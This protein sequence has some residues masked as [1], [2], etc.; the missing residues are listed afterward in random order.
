M[1]LHV[2]AVRPEQVQDAER[3]SAQRSESTIDNSD[4]ESLA[5]PQDNANPTTSRSTQLK[6]L[7]GSAQ[8]MTSAKELDQ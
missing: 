4:G 3:T 2:R 1:W 8:C 7:E 6:R 5:D